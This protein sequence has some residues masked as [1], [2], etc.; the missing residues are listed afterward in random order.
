MHFI[1]CFQLNFYNLYLLYSLVSLQFSATSTATL[2]NIFI[3]TKLQ[4]AT[5]IKSFSLQLLA[6]NYSLQLLL[7]NIP[8]MFSKYTLGD[9]QPV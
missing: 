9:F 6:N 1:C 2:P 8:Y 3:P 5:L 4:L 7:P